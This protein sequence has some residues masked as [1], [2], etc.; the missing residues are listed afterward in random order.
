ME[1]FGKRLFFYFFIEVYVIFLGV[2]PYVV[3]CLEVFFL[4]F[5]FDDFSYLFDFQ[6]FV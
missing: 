5:S 1:T 4:F 6:Y 3:R 2:F